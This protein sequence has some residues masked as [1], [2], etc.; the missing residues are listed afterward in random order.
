MVRYLP[1]VVPHIPPTMRW[2]AYVLLPSTSALASLLVHLSPIAD[3]CCLS[4][5]CAAVTLLPLSEGR[6]ALLAGLPRG[7]GRNETHVI[8]KAAYSPVA[9][10]RTAFQDPQ[11]FTRP[12]LDD[13][14]RLVDDVVTRGPR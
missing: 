7:Q 4:H 13:M 11:L 12:A 2:A 8:W 10:S 1:Y 9:S 6:R 5:W 3:L 14:D